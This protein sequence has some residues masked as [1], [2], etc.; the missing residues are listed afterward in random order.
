MSVKQLVP[1][2]REKE[3]VSHR[4]KGFGRKYAGKDQEG[5]RKDGGLT[6]MVYLY[7][8]MICTVTRCTITD[9]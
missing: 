1:C 8:C 3:R 9:Y 4:E 5:T 2:G 6:D 7:L